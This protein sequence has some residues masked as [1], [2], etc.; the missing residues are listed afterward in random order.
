MVG[1]LC[2]KCD[3]VYFI[4]ST[5]DGTSEGHFE[6]EV[7]CD[8]EEEYQGY[9]ASQGKP[10][11]KFSTLPYFYYFILNS[12]LC[13]TTLYYVILV[14]ESSSLRAKILGEPPNHYP[15]T[16]LLVSSRASN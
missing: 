2:L 1:C 7:Y 11:Y 4:L 9:F 15:Q 13:T 3:C 12:K 8:P 10:S 5:L 16:I 6:E 14:V